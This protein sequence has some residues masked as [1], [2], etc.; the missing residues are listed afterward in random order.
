M[1]KKFLKV[2]ALSAL[3]LSA[4]G[5][6]ANNAFPMFGNDSAVKAE[7]AVGD[8]ESIT[9]FDG[10]V[11]TSISN[12]KLI[13]KGHASL[14]YD[15]FTYGSSTN[16]NIKG[17]AS[18]KATS[19]SIYFKFSIDVNYKLNSI[20][21][22]YAT[23]GGRVFNVCDSISSNNIV[24]TYTAKKTKSASTTINIDST[25][26]LKDFY[27]NVT[28][29][30]FTLGKVVINIEQTSEPVLVS[31][32]DIK[33]NNVSVNSNTIEI[34]E[35][36]DI[37]LTA[38]I[39]PENA[40]E[41][42]I[43]WKIVGED[44]NETDIATIDQ[45]G[46]V[47]SNLKAGKVKVVVT[48]KDDS[49]TSS[50]VWINYKEI[51]KCKITLDYN[52]DINEAKVIV[53]PKNDILSE[54]VSDP[55]R[56]GYQFDGWYNGNDKFDINTVISSD[57]TLTAHWKK[58]LDAQIAVDNT[59]VSKQNQIVSEAFDLTQTKADDKYPTLEA[60]FGTWSVTE[61]PYILKTANSN[62]TGNKYGSDNTEAEDTRCMKSE[63]K[64]TYTYSSSS[65]I[66]TIKK[67]TI[68][69]FYLVRR[70]ESNTASNTFE[71]TSDN[72]T[73]L[74]FVANNES[75]D[76]V[77][78][79]TV[80]N[81]NKYNYTFIDD[82]SFT[83]NFSIKHS[84]GKT[85]IQAITFDYEKE[86]LTYDVSN[87][88]LSMRLSASLPKDMFNG[89]NSATLKTHIVPE[90]VEEKTQ[91]KEISDLSKLEYTEGYYEFGIVI[92]D[93]PIAAL[94]KQVT[95]YFEII[96]GDE[97]ITTAS[98]TTTFREL[99]QAYID[100]YDNGNENIKAEVSEESYIM[101][102]TLNAYG[103]S[104]TNN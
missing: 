3:L 99:V 9:L 14:I 95:T 41:K 1:K 62:L 69:S 49:K 39:L 52:D 100:G 55:I 18:D 53:I 13:E 17:L 68:L 51:E 15:G 43:E 75:V 19:E 23:N 35:G 38:S 44:D 56:N 91:T 46:N 80:Y 97:T 102:N 84:D 74:T 60:K 83:N 28:K 45:N 98:R 29:G 61:D 32:I 76:G 94:D 87:S 7:A 12:N 93:M 85:C 64:G 11:D 30:S 66:N 50:F 27:I 72:N 48:S 6:V 37:S 4:G 5:V 22:N 36:E 92:K 16:S 25:N 96:V 57:L 71:I 73:K 2:F 58:T 81:V 34:D 24:G 10:S 40:T 104:E 42:S 78:D 89:A 90:G 70:N 8:T 67:G 82:F 26:E 65:S 88:T 54:Y 86:D 103:K 31:S 21:L 101:L 20:N 77:E 33:Y 59:N 79:T 47:K 63:N